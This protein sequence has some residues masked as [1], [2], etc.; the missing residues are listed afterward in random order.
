MRILLHICWSTCYYG[1]KLR[2]RTPSY[3]HKGNC[4]VWKSD[5]YCPL[6]ATE[7]S[8]SKCK[9]VKATQIASHMK[10]K[11]ASMVT[12]NKHVSSFPMWNLLPGYCINRIGSIL[13]QM[14]LLWLSLDLPG[15]FFPALLIKLIVWLFI[16][17]ALILPFKWNSLRQFAW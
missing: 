8:L 14:N 3:L 1:W 4:S 10:W 7:P 6:R 11:I 2:R 17:S 5:K 15:W 16:S 13:L 9:I 12:D